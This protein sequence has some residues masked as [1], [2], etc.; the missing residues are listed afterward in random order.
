MKRVA[1]TDPGEHTVVVEPVVGIVQV[2]LAV[3]RVAVDVQH[4]AVTVRV[5][6]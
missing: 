6:P 3:V 1:R 4:A 5:L 2:E